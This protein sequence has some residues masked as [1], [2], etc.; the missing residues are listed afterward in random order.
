MK[1]PR[2]DLEIG[3]APISAS[4]PPEDAAWTMDTEDAEVWAFTD[5]AEPMLI[6]EEGYPVPTLYDMNWDEPLIA[7]W[8]EMDMDPSM[9]YNVT[10]EWVYDPMIAESMPIDFDDTMEMVEWE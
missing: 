4:A 2:K 6:D 5:F 3:I 1:E 7:T 8:E 9:Y 10:E